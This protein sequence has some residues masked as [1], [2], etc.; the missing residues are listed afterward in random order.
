MTKAAEH[1]TCIRGEV[2]GSINCYVHR[3]EGEF[4]VPDEVESRGYP[5]TAEG[6]FQLFIEVDRNLLD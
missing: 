5:V 3:C 6:G 2:A 1:L 4:T